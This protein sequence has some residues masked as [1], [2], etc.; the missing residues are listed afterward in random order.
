MNV[1]HRRKLK[2]GKEHVL[3]EL[4][5]DEELIVVR[6]NAHYRL[7]YPIEDVVPSHVVSDSTPV[8]WCPISQGWVND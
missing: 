6:K 3:V 4:D 7:G 1:K 2:N 5:S 8:V